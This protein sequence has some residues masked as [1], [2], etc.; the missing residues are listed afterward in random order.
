MAYVDLETCD[1]RARCYVNGIVKD[2]EGTNVPHSAHWHPRFQQHPWVQQS[3]DEGWARELRSVVIG[4]LKVMMLKAQ[5]RF[6]YGAIRIEDLMPDLKWVEHTRKE[7]ASMQR[8]V[9]WQK[10][11]NYD[12]YK[13]IDHPKMKPVDRPAFEKMMRESPNRGLYRELSTVTR[14]M[15]GDRLE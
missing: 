14:R 4:N 13:R 12:K 6:S 5:D 3:D 1:Y 15:T 8:G 2:K 7:A 11:S 9:E 10:D